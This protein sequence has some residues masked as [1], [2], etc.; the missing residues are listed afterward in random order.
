MIL[1]LGASPPHLLLLLGLNF[2]LLST[3]Q[4]LVYLLE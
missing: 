2:L 3:K 4:Y 1:A